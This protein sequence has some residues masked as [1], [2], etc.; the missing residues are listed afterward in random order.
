MSLLDNPDFAREYESLILNGG[1]HLENL[2]SIL[3]PGSHEMDPLTRSVLFNMI[4]QYIHRV[5]KCLISGDTIQEAHAQTISEIMRDPVV[6]R[7]VQDQL[8]SMIDGSVS[9]FQEEHI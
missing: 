7:L 6:D 4:G 3:A 2:L 9:R 1:P 8:K 5:R